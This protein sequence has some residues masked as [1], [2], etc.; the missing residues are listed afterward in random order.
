MLLLAKSKRKEQVTK[1]LGF[2]PATSF[3]KETKSSLLTL[4]ISEE[5]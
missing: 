4:K 3:Q 1:H 2:S 5:A